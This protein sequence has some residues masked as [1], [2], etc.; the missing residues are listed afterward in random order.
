[1]YACVCN[2]IREKDI[3]AIR[4]RSNTKEEFVTEL[5]KL[6]PESSCMICY[7]DVIEMYGKSE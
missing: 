4:E 2:A 6:F 1:M 3:R 7:T 5:K